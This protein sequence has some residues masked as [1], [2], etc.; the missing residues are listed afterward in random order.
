MTTAEMKIAIKATN[1]HKSFQGPSPVTILKGL[2]LEIAAGTTTAIV[3]RSG[4]GKS[5]LLHILGTLENPNEGSLA[6]AGH[7]V[8]HFSSCLQCSG[9]TPYSE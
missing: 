1:I 7:D 4:E 8:S 9:E 6:I 5:T 2:N 3:G